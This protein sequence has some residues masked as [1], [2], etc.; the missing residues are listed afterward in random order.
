MRRHAFSDLFSKCLLARS[1]RTQADLVD[2]LFNS[3]EKRVVRIFLLMAEVGKPGEPETL[4]PKITHET[5]AESGLS[6]ARLSGRGYVSNIEQ[7]G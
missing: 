6:Q 4:I 1:M 3:S 7:Y 2:Q 5:L